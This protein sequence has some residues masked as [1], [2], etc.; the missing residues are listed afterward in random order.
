MEKREVFKQIVND[1]SKAV[2]NEN[3]NNSM[4][5]DSVTITDYDIVNFK[6][7]K[8]NSAKKGSKPRRSLKNENKNIS[9]SGQRNRVNLSKITENMVNS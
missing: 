5:K 9:Q 3:I 4:E 1:F 6:S 8:L 7:K 2:K